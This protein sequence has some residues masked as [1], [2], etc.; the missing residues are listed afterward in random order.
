MTH[1]TTPHSPKV[2]AALHRRWP[3][4]LAVGV[5]ILGYRDLPPRRRRWGAAR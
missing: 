2:L 3:V 1:T 5:V 4:M